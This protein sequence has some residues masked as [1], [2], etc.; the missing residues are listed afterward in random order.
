MPN[1]PP[2]PDHLR[3]LIEKRTGKDRRKKNE[4]RPA[5]NED[6]NAVLHRQPRDRRQNKNFRDLLNDDDDE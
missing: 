5:D 1:D 3:S 2:L 4:G 6:G